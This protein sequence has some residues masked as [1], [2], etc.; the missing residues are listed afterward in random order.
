MVRILSV[1]TGGVPMSWLTAEEA[2]HK[3]ASGEVAWSVG[4]PIVVFR[5]GINKITGLRSVIESPPIIAVTGS[6]VFSKKAKYHVNISGKEML[7][8]RDLNTCAYCGNTYSDNK[9]SIDHIVPKSKWPKNQP[10][11]H[12][13]MNCVT[14]CKPC[15]HYKADKTLDESGM[16]LL[17]LPYV[18]C[19]Y[20][21]FL[22][23]GRKVLFDQMQYLKAKLPKHSR[24]L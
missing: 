21:A 13:W 2:V 1:D 18:P 4:D 8:A 10:G 12:G 3:I 20:E 16:E 23:S 11:K 17:Y 9:L 14:A 24:L 6:E 5:G 19:R 22:L 15:N 7:F